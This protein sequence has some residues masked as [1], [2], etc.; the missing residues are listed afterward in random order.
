MTRPNETLYRFRAVSVEPDLLRVGSDRYSLS[1]LKEVSCTC[2]KKQRGARRFGLPP[3]V[4][5]AAVAFL[6]GDFPWGV[7][8]GVGLLCVAVVLLWISAAVWE[9]RVR[10]ADGW[11]KVLR[12]SRKS[13]SKALVKE[14]TAAC[15]RAR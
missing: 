1:S 9:V 12:T 6:F 2:S 13:V 4:A 15:K 3:V 11:V 8:I 7:V 10:T 5:S 14:L